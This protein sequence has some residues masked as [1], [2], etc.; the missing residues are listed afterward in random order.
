MM[1]WLC[2]G[3]AAFV[4]T[5]ILPRTVWRSL[6]EPLLHLRAGLLSGRSQLDRA[7]Y[8][9]GAWLAR[10]A[11]AEGLSDPLLKVRHFIGS[12]VYAAANAMFLCAE[13]A[14]VLMTLEA[15]GLVESGSALAEPGR[16]MAMTVVVGGVFFGALL[17]E[18]LGFLSFFP[19][20]DSASKRVRRFYW[21]LTMFGLALA[22]GLGVCLAV[23]RSS[24]LDSAPA[25]AVQSAS[26]ITANGSDGPE[27]TDIERSMRWTTIIGLSVLSAVGAVASHIGPIYTAKWGVAGAVS[28]VMGVLGCGRLL[29]SALFWIVSIIM[30]FYL[31]LASIL[32]RL[33]VAAMRPVVGSRCGDLEIPAQPLGR[34]EELSQLWTPSRPALPEAERQ[35]EPAQAVPAEPPAAEAAPNDDGAQGSCMAGPREP[36]PVSAP[37]FPASESS[38]FAAEPPT[39]AWN[40][41]GAPPVVQPGRSD[42]TDKDQKGKQ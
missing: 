34:V 40:P 11:I 2:G 4:V 12:L 9:I 37:A 27:E 33:A 10:L 23:G 22:M 19:K 17:I 28:L 32:V 30:A 6:T 24:M 8:A 18:M 1:T 21:V 16:V 29:M 15:Q 38:E 42:L 39:Q 35:P 31:G 20:L 26:D 7:R 36:D 41:W 3:L 5:G 25:V 14:I 13:I